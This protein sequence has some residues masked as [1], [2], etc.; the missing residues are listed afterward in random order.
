MTYFYKLIPP[1]PDFPAD[2]T[3]AEASAMQQHVAYWT[4]LM[5]KGQVLVFGP[6]ADPHGS[7]GIAVLQLDEGADPSSV[8]AND[9]AIK[10]NAGFQF[11]VYPM[12][13]AVMP[14]LTR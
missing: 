2:I 1:R 11:E 14:P 10:A 8:G 7:F 6:V 3:P 5:N 4:E 9:P 13:R 12:P